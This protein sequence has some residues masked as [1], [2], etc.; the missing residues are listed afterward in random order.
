MVYHILDKAREAG[1][2]FLVVEH[3]KGEYRLVFGGDEDVAVYG[4]NST[5]APLLM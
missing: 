1:V 2:Y 4:T 5:L 3:A